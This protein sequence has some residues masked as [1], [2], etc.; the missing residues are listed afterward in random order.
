MKLAFLFIAITSCYGQTAFRFVGATC[1]ANSLTL[2]SFGQI[3]TLSP[4][5]IQGMVIANCQIIPDLQF[6]TIGFTDVE[7]RVW[8][9]ISYA[10]PASF[11]AKMK[12]ARILAD[13]F[14]ASVVLTPPIALPPSPANPAPGMFVESFQLD[15]S[16]VYTLSRVPA[17]G[18]LLIVIFNSSQVGADKVLAVAPQGPDTK[19]IQVIPPP[20]YQPYSSDNKLT[21]A[22]WSYQ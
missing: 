22:Y 16:E 6:Q 10:A 15:N 1:N 18:T 2:S 4:V 21:V 9:S 8:G 3:I 13:T 11:Q 20:G 12:T 7:L 19:I 17:P 14:A 5:Q